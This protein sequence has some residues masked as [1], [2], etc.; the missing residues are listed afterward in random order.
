MQQ[1]ASPDGSCRQNGSPATSGVLSTRDGVNVRYAYCADAPGNPWIALVMPFGLDLALAQ[2][3]FDFFR[4]H[5]NVCTWES[6][7]I[8]EDSMRECTVE[9][10]SIDRHAEDLFAVLEALQVER[11][12]LV[13]YCS[14][15]GIALAA[16]NLAPNLFTTVV[17]AHGEYTLLSRP[18]CTTPFAA[19]MDGLLS[20]AASG[21]ERAKL[22]YEKIH[23]ERFDFGGERPHGLDVPFSE[24]RFL[25]RY[26]R[27]YLAYKAND[28]EQLA[29]E[30][31]HPALLLAGGR[32]IQVNTT[33]SQRI[34]ARMPNADLFVDPEADHY[35]LLRSDSNTMIAVWNYLCEGGY[36]RQ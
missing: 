18:D 14:G 3:F 27:N 28:Y 7:S 23:N 12:I 25:K 4:S 35:G 9:E 34:H 5:Y 10:F 16:A 20:L 2:P 1:S 15:A 30:V 19:D 6:R 24:L 17:L 26:A 33:S 36:A 13:G 8:L 29:T 22:V 32:D 21:D 31:S 11:A